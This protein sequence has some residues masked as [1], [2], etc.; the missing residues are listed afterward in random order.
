[1]PGIQLGMETGLQPSE[2]LISIREERLFHF[3]NYIRRTT[4]GDRAAPDS[5]E[6]E[7]SGRAFSE[8]SRPCAVSLHN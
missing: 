3:Q 8:E 2:G 4:Q 6:F 7:V 5:G 1:M